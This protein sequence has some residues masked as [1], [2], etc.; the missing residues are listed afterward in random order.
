MVS[1]RLGNVASYKIEAAAIVS[2][3]PAMQNLPD[4]V[5]TPLA[6]TAGAERVALNTSLPRGSSC[7]RQSWGPQALPSGLDTR[8]LHN[9]IK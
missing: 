6:A 1:S 9:A 2:E 8:S 7:F 4:R 3:T 5:V